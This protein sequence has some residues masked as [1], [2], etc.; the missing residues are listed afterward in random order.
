MYLDLPFN[1]LINDQVL[2]TSTVHLEDDESL[3]ISVGF[4]PTSDVKKCFAIDRC[5]TLDYHDHP[6]T[7]G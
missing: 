4:D 5:L 2:T 6:H 1:L 3:T 7:V